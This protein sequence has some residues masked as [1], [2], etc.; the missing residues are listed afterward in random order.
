[1]MNRTGTYKYNKETGEVEKVSDR[2][3]S[4]SF[5]CYVPEGGYL[6]D[7][8]GHNPVYVTSRRQKTALLKAAGLREKQDLVGGRE[9]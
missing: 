7:N 5:S 4:V 8:L 9:I 1:M 3:P 2:V 6:A